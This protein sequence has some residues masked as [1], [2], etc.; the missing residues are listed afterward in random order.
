MMSQSSVVR[1]G[2]EPSALPLMRE[3]CAPEGLVHMLSASCSVLKKYPFWRARKRPAS[4]KQPVIEWRLPLDQLKT[5]VEKMYESRRAATV[6]FSDRCVVQGQPMQIK[7]LITNQMLG[8]YV[9]LLDLPPGTLRL[10]RA[11]LFM[12]QVESADAAAAQPW[13]KELGL[14][15]M[16]PEQDDGAIRPLCR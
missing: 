12:Q 7:A 11:T 10:V 9:R 1:A 13:S 2:L 5:A 6:G 16:S 3:C 14:Q 15:P 4:A 8:V